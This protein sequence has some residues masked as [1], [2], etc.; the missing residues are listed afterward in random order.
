[1]YFGVQ[2]TNKENHYRKRGCYGC[3]RMNE[4]NRTFLLSE[5][6]VTLISI[7]GRGSSISSAKQG[8]SGFI[9]NLVKN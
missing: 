8:K 7:S 1:M 3:F 5:E 2:F 9:Y 4:Y 6:A